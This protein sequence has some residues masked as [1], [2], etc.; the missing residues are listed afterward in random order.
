MDAVS[1]AG[2]KIDLALLRFNQ[3]RY[4]ASNEVLLHLVNLGKRSSFIAFCIGRNYLHLEQLEDARRWFEIALTF[5][6]PFRWTHYVFARLLDA[7]KRPGEAARHLVS[8]LDTYKGTPSLPELNPSQLSF[9]LR[10]AHLCFDQGDSTAV[11][12]YRACDAMGVRDYLCELRII[13]QTLDLPDV[14]QATARMGRLRTMHKPDVW[15]EFV[16]ARLYFAEGH[17]DLAIS[18]AL[19]AAAAE[20][21]NTFVKVTA[22]HKLLEF[23]AINEASRYIESDLVPLLGQNDETDKN[24]N[25]MRF[26]L[27][28]LEEDHKQILALCRSPNFLDSVPNWLVVEA[29]FKFALPGDEVNQLDIEVAAELATFLE[30]DKPYTLGTVL[31]LYQFFSRRRMWGRIQAL[32]TYIKDHEV[33]SHHEVLL[34]RFEILCNTSQLEQAKDFYK[35]HYAR[36]EL[37]HWEACIVLRFLAETSM[38]DEAA[39]LLP[40][41]ISKKYYLPDG[42]DFLLRICRKTRLHEVLLKLI[43]EHGGHGAPAQFE[44]LRD[45]L[46]DDLVIRHCAGQSWDSSGQPRE[47]SDRNRSLLKQAP[48]LIAPE[49]C[50][51][52]CSDKAYFLSVTTFLA[53]F[54]LCKTAREPLAWYVFLAEGVPKSWGIIL[55]E[56]SKDLGLEVRVVFEREFVES[57]ALHVE[58]YGIFT[59]GNTL[60]RAAFLR[61]YAATYLYKLQLYDRAL[62]VDSDIVCQKDIAPFFGKEF[63]ESLIMARAEEPTPEVQTVSQ[64]HGLDEMRYFNSGVLAFN[65]LNDSLPARL[66]HAIHL[67]EHDSGRLVFHDQCALNIAFKDHVSYLEP[68]FNFFLRP[69]RSDNGDPSSAILLHFLDRPKPWDLSYNREYRTLWMRNADIARLLLS[70]EHYNAFVASANA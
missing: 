44:T 27:A 58:R 8:F 52:L 65:F 31:S 33:F 36:C 57:S 67:A 51:F 11:E 22:G 32:E 16:Q 5:T 64:T 17:V 40:R 2:E 49:R 15:G 55:E 59:G 9:L 26:R 63:G 60:S 41:F 30:H 69:H 6:P 28:V 4:E 3:Q 45:L 10:I 14:P 18:T 37:R 29:L 43:D 38:W 53:S 66:G 25:G 39:E 62:Y 34:R 56:Y 7:E 21:P 68:Q 42:E 46:N 13:E 61:I 70:S 12:L 23:G 19:A 54:A 20:P 1:P 50:A 35:Q 47:I 24:I 48:L